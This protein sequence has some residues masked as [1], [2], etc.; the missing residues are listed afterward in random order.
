[1]LLAHRVAWLLLRGP[2][3][4]GMELDHTCRNRAC[5]NPAHLEPVT[6]AENMRRA[7]EAQ[8]TCKRGHA[9]T[10]ETTV[11]DRHGHRSCRICRRRAQHAYEARKATA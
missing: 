8:T 3:T 5:V 11:I 1:M 9:Y 2:I 10:P 6:H 4:A 7:S